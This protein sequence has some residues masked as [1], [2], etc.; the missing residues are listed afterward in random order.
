[1]S[2]VLVRVGQERRLVVRTVPRPPTR[3]VIPDKPEL[4][5][6]PERTVTDCASPRVIASARIELHVEPGAG[7][8]LPGRQ[9]RSAKPCVVAVSIFHKSRIPAPY[10]SIDGA[11]ARVCDRTA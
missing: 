2:E 11:A 4:P 10:T 5:T 7:I 1:M 6:L 8:H 9:T 3:E